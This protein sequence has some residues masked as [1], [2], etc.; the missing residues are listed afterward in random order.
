M[1]MRSIHRTEPLQAHCDSKLNGEKYQA[2]R[3]KVKYLWKAAM[4]ATKMQQAAET[5]HIIT[6]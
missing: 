5:L 3:E 2:S 4:G 6:L 1:K